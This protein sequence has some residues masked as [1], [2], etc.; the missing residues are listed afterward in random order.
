MDIE[1]YLVV[2]TLIYK[3]KAVDR[4]ENLKIKY[5]FLTYNC[6]GKLYDI[7]MRDFKLNDSSFFNLNENTGEI[8]TKKVLDFEQNQH[9]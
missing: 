9:F 8:Y 1:D 5:K 6:C 4:D 2:N 7:Y 3:L